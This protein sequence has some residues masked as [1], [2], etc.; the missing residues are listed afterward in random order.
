MLFPKYS[1]LKIPFQQH[2]ELLLWVSNSLRAI[3]FMF[4]FLF[5]VRLLSDLSIH[6]CVL[7]TDTMA[8]W[9]WFSLNT[10][11][12]CDELK[13]ALLYC[14]MGG[15]IRILSSSSVICLVC[16]LCNQA[17]DVRGQGGG[18][19]PHITSICH[20]DTSAVRICQA[21]VDWPRCSY[22]VVHEDLTAL[23]LSS[24]WRT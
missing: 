19:L 1:I 13:C 4:S 9:L 6:V 11:W 24:S 12:V 15:L 21:T 14:R 23:T 5:R 2:N 10:F 18:W 3:Y 22:T 8:L 7:A 16:N 20:I 17:E